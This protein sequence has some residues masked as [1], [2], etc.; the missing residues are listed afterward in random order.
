METCDRMHLLTGEG[1]HHS[2][3]VQVFGIVGM[4]YESSERKNFA[5]TSVINGANWD[6]IISKKF[7]SSFPGSA[8]DESLV[9]RNSLTV[10]APSST[11]C[12]V[13]GREQ[14]NCTSTQ[15][16]PSPETNLFRDV[17][18]PGKCL[19][20]ESDIFGG[21]RKLDFHSVSSRKGM[22]V[23]KYPEIVCGEGGC[24]SAETRQS[25]PKN[26]GG[27][28]PRALSSAFHRQ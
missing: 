27:T 3:G 9:I 22:T 24:H 13:R 8:V 11:S 10:T 14:N 28:A 5:P 2:S 16:Q 17:A 26:S 1:G 20:G 23:E 21:G 6:R 18:F 7:F 15:L 4:N 12:P 19:S 25:A